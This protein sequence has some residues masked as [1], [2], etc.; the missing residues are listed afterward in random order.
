MPFI[1]KTKFT[2]RL[3]LFLKILLVI[4]FS[5]LLLYRAFAYLYFESVKAANAEN[6]NK[7]VSNYMYAVQYARSV[8]NQIYTDF[9]REKYLLEDEDVI[10]RYFYQNKLKRYLGTTQHLESF[11]LISNGRLYHIGN[12]TNDEK[13]WELIHRCKNMQEPLWREN[14]FENS[15]VSTDY[16]YSLL[17]CA[18]ADSS[19]KVDNGIL[20]N[21]NER[22]AE[23]FAAGGTSQQQAFVFNSE[24][25][26][27]LSTVS[28]TK[29]REI[30]NSLLAHLHGKKAFGKL[31][32]ADAANTSYYVTAS[33]ADGKTFVVLAKEENFVKA[34]RKTLL[35]A[36]LVSLGFCVLVFL[37]MLIY[38]QYSL[39]VIRTM[40]QQLEHSEKRY[41]SN[42]EKLKANYCLNLLY[43]EEENECTEEKLKEYNICLEAQEKI[44]LLLI[45]ADH[46]AESE[47]SYYLMRKVQELAE[48]IWKQRLKGEW[49]TVDR[50][51]SVYIAAFA[52]DD[53]LRKMAEELQSAFYAQTGHTISVFIGQSGTLHESATLFSELLIAKKQKFI[54]GFSCVV[55]WEEKEFAVETDMSFYHAS[56]QNIQDAIRRAQTAKAEKLFAEFLQSDFVRHSISDISEIVKKMLFAFFLELKPENREDRNLLFRKIDEVETAEEALSLF[57]NM[58]KASQRERE[59]TSGKEKLVQKVEQYI[60]DNYADSNL[61]V[62]SIA[63]FVGLSS[64]YLGQIYKR[65][66]NQGVGDYI[67]SKRMETAK[68]LIETTT[69]PLT[70]IAAKV[71]I[72]NKT[73]FYKLFQKYYNATPSVFRNR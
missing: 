65:E 6:L 33:K 19:G 36:A 8:A 38:S 21:F 57:Q 28:A 70:E 1:A 72:T 34:F 56:E 52:E 7:T 49:V 55:F 23:Q 31:K 32:N 73:H 51:S 26:V 68:M 37:A 39:M 24:E 63:E 27:I 14:D 66:R 16:V 35:I 29:Y 17:Y 46:A 20:M 58:L 42:K 53:M 60:D 47:K 54:Q 43:N 45:E 69:Q 3:T 41:Q 22:W 59:E 61:S 2:R 62:A 5:S 10:Q 64:G 9:S 18:S 71:G 4:L 67:N 11:V 12:S 50:T 15:A 48:D 30:E 40:K 25:Q 13:T 44:R